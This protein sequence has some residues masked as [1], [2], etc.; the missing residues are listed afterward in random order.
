MKY[1]VFDVVSTNDETKQRYVTVIITE[2]FAK[3][4]SAVKSNS[5]YVQFLEMAQLTDA[6]VKKLTPDVWYDFP[7]P[8]P[9]EPPVETIV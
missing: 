1:E 7:A 9:V 5:D 4:F 8:L 3:T 2:D 6:A